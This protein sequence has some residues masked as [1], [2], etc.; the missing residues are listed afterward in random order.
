VSGDANDV[1][2]VPL[3]D[4]AEGTRSF[5]RIT[6]IAKVDE[7]QIATLI[8]PLLPAWSSEQITSCHCARVACGSSKFGG[9][10]VAS[11]CGL[12]QKRPHRRCHASSP[13]SVVESDVTRAV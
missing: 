9:L 11:G 3:I 12:K 8:D 13:N 7:F 6:A 4:D 1:V 5:G 2:L 10:A